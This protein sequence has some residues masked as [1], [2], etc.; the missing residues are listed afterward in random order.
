M[1][2]RDFMFAN[3]FFDI[4]DDVLQQTITM[5][6]LNYAGIKSL[7]GILPLQLA[8]EKRR[9]CYNYLVAWQ[10]MTLYPLNVVGGTTGVGGMPL[11][12]KS[13]HDVHLT[14]KET[15]AQDSVL[16]ELTTNV[17]GIQ[18]LAMIQTAPE[19]YMLR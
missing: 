15:T 1:L 3:K 14:F 5:V 13:I 18:A 19:C 16:S 4:S 2:P 11:V 17:F 12:S 8:E 10:L 9:L 6:E 7:W